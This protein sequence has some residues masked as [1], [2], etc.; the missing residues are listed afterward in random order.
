M[1][2]LC[3]IRCCRM[4][5]AQ[6]PLPQGSTDSFGSRSKICRVSC[7]LR[8]SHQC[9]SSIHELFQPWV[10]L[11]ESWVASRRVGLLHARKTESTALCLPSIRLNRDLEPVE[12]QGRIQLRCE[13]FLSQLPG[14]CLQ[15]ASQVIEF[16][17]E[18][19]TDLVLEGHLGT[20][21]L[22]IPR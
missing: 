15:A 21:R 8:N 17:T 16:R 14:A 12:L 19:S 22:G 9:L 10:L 4:I 20:R 11:S 7:S 1:I 3:H 18:T 5:C 13:L 6:L 2:R